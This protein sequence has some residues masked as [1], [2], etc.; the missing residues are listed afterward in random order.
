MLKK[1]ITSSILVLSL[2]G[3]SMQAPPYQ[4]SLENVQI[5]K[6]AKVAPANVGTVTSDS[7]LNKISLRGSKM[8]SP[9]GESYGAY[10]AQ[11]IEAELKLANAWA[12]VSSTVITGELIEN[13]IDVSGFSTGVGVS[14]AK[15]TIT[16]NGE[17]LYQKVISAEHTF[18]SSFMGNI[19]IPNGQTNYV[20]LINK[21]IKTLFE[22]QEF[23]T[24]LKS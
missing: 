4:A 10:I 19:A 13:D 20:N 14:S 17:T 2:A 15:F 23:T 16:K 11:A 6:R 21:L 12:P 9:V 7:K 3:C 1:I 8:Y 22:D 5:L 24:A 18:D